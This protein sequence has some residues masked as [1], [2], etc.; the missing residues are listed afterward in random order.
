MPLPSQHRPFSSALL[1]N[2]P[3]SFSPQ[4]PASGK[5]SS[6]KNGSP[7]KCPRFLKVKNWET[8]VVLTD[9]LHLK[10][11][12]VSISGGCRPGSIHL[13]IT[14]VW[15]Q[16]LLCGGDFLCT[17]Q[18]LKTFLVVTTSEATDI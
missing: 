8:D 3:S 9:T 18:Y 1:P 13:S 16:I 5:Q 15:D 14:H 6:P 2:V 17:W 10:S 7:S 11:T 12:L 4:A